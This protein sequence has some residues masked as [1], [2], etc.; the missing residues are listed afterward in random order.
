M[1]LFAW[2]M[3]DC[4]A[5]VVYCASIF[6]IVAMSGRV[7]IESQVKHP[8]RTCILW[9]SFACCLLDIIFVFIES[10]GQPERYGVVTGLTWSLSKPAIWHRFSMN[11]S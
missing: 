5:V 4:V 11:A 6:V 9:V 7:D 2:F 1:T 8:K 3:C 10:T